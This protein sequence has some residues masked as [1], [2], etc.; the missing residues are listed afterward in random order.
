MLEHAREVIVISDLH[1]GG[2][3][4]TDGRG[5]GFRMNTRAQELK[6]FLDDLTARSPG[7][8]ELVINGDFLDVLAERAPGQ[9]ATLDPYVEADRDVFSD[10]LER[11]QAVFTSL[12]ALARRQRLTILLGNHD[13]ELALPPFRARFEKAIET[14]VGRHVKF[15]DDN[16]AYVIGSVLIEHGNRYD[17]FNTVAHDD[18]RRLRSLVS[19]GERDERVAFPP[20]PGSRLVVEI[21]NR[22]KERYPFIDLLKPET[23]AAVPLLLAFEPSHAK[24]GPALMSLYLKK[25][26]LEPGDDFAYD[27]AH[28]SARGEVGD[29]PIADVPAE[30]AKAIVDADAR[31]ELGIRDLERLLDEEAPPAQGDELAPMSAAKRA[32]QLLGLVDLMLSGSLE[33]RMRGLRR[34]LQVVRDDRSF[35]IGADDVGSP[36]VAAA[37]HL[38]RGTIRHVVFGHTHLAKAI[39]LGD[40]R[41][42]TNTGTWADLAQLPL[43]ELLVLD[44]A[45][46]ATKFSEFLTALHTTGQHEW[47]RWDPY[48]ATFTVASDGTTPEGPRLVKAW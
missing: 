36:W 48:F 19:R 16:E 39:D 3:Y 12:G 1:L 20:P 14:E 29:A 22:I 42:Y 37:H 18:L 9:P 6:A 46:L 35:V 40:G 41:S 26:K 13:V 21:M 33:K 34:A 4:P 23:S 11:D 2:R 32:S 7:S 43:D 5:R 15:V 8:I 24:H 10:L 44:D 45:A 25:R 28:M 38:A 17:G 47:I 27:L 31:C 30:V